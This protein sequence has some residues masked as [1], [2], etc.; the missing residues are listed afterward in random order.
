MKCFLIS[1]K[2]SASSK[3]SI[4]LQNRQAAQSLQQEFA[5]WDKLSDEALLEFEKEL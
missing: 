5:Q 3:E 2:L 4:L 1:C